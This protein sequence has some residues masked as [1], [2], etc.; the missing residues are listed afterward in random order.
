MDEFLKNDGA[1]PDTATQNGST[2]NQGEGTSASHGIAR[3]E[4]GWIGTEWLSGRNAPFS[5]QKDSSRKGGCPFILFSEHFFHPISNLQVNRRRFYFD[6]VST[7]MHQAVSKETLGYSWNNSCNLQQGE[8]YN[9]R[10][11]QG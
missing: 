4:T 3:D 1:R 5:L 8:G 10:I 9:M 11:T 2:T 6:N 7:C